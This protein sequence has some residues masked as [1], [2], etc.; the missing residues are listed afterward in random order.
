M[1]S[2]WKTFR[3]AKFG[4]SAAWALG[5]TTLATVLGQNP[6]HAVV[7]IGCQQTDTNPIS[8]SGGSN[9]GNPTQLSNLCDGAQ[10]A[11]SGNLPSYWE[12]TWN[13]A[14]GN[15]TIGATITQGSPSVG[16]F[17]AEVDLLTTNGTVL[18][19]SGEFYVP[20]SVSGTDSASLIY[21]LTKG[22]T[23]EFGLVDDGNS[24]TLQLSE[25][26]DPGYAV[27]FSATPTPEPASLGIFGGAL[28]ALTAFRRRRKL[29]R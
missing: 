4:T 17:Y 8:T 22:A 10:I 14:S 11:G 27:T 13:D 20:G 29:S 24:N 23:Y 16:S 9:T 18:G 28:A 5:V 12:F 7:A 21:N 25:S 15:T 2:V 3:A 1:D 6:A 26:V 19:S